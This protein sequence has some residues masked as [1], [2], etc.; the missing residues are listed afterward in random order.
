MPNVLIIED[1]VADVFLIR[2]AFKEVNP[3]R[4]IHI[5]KNGEDA[6]TFLTKK[7]NDN[8]YEHLSLIILDINLPK[9]NGHEV[10]QF[11]KSTKYLQQIPVVMFT[12][13]SSPKDVNDAYNY[14]ANSFIVKPMD[15]EGLQKIVDGLENYW[16][17]IVVLPYNK[18]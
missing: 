18:C 7:D 5:V 8:E 17:N 3:K 4:I 11:I 15:Y 6:I 1:N 13:S 10:L 14:C 16:F 12:T 9:K 2:Q